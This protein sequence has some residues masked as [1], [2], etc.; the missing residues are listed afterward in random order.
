MSDYKQTLILNRIHPKE[1][2]SVILEEDYSIG[3][4]MRYFCKN[5]ITNKIIEIDVNTYN[6][7]L[8]KL[9]DYAHEE[10]IFVQIY[11][12]LT[13]PYRD[14]RDGNKIFYGV[15]DTNKRSVSRISK[16]MDGIDKKLIDLAE[17]SKLSISVPDSKILINTAD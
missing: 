10:Y 12:K 9:Q 5:I 17:F 14:T 8:Q 11:W 7:F 13:G 6:L 3:F 15:Y 4:K 1:S 16:I 2:I